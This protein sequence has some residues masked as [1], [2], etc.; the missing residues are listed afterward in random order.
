M[1]EKISRL[2]DANKL[3]QDFEMSSQYGGIVFTPEEVAEIIDEYDTVEERKKGKWICKDSLD[4]R[5]CSVCNERPY[6]YQPDFVDD[7]NWKPKYCPNCGADMRGDSN[8]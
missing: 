4:W 3:K 2:I 1:D 5:R 8:D 7:M 6:P